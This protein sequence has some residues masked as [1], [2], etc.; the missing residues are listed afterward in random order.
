MWITI[1]C[2]ASKPGYYGVYAPFHSIGTIIKNIKESGIKGNFLGN[3]MIFIPFGILLSTLFGAKRKWYWPVIAGFCFSLF[4]ETIQLITA[5]GYF[6]P[7]DVMLNT[8]GT[9]IGYLLWKA[10][11]HRKP[12]S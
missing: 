2:R 7:D 6:D 8:V 1:I 9:V 5:K 3:I 10:Y 11:I 12:A 4:I